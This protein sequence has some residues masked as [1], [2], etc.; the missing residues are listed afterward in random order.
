MSIRFLFVVT[1]LVLAL[2]VLSPARAQ[3]DEAAADT[4][5]AEAGAAEAVEPAAVE[6]DAN[7]IGYFL[8]LSMGQQMRQNGFRPTDI[9]LQSLTAGFGDGI[10]DQESALDDQQLAATQS[11]IQQLLPVRQREQLAAAKQQGKQFLA[12]NA[13]Q[14]GVQVL[15]G[16]VQYRVIQAGDG[17]SPALT[18]TVKVHYTGK[19][20]NGQMF[21]SSVQRGEPAVFRVGQVI[22]GWQMALQEMKVGAKWMLYIP[23]ELAYGEKGSPGAIGPNQV[24][25]FEVE[26]LEIQ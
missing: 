14:E 24:L 15:E 6:P 9:D 20:I 12:D 13:K 1:P 8:G 21:D 2:M 17:K 22:K 7:Q 11:M 18:D 10:A 23:S 4:P 25:I 19:L 5:A 16:G 26:L 3:D